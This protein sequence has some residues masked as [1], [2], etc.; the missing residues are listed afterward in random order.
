MAPLVAAV[1]ARVGLVVDGRA[2][3]VGSAPVLTHDA[4]AVVAAA[5]E[6]LCVVA[7]VAVVRVMRLFRPAAVAV[8][9]AA[10]HVQPAAHFAHVPL[11]VVRSVLVAAVA[12]CDVVHV[13]RYRCQAAVEPAVEEQLVVTRFARFAVHRVLVARLSL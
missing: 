8:A 5:A 11:A 3:L 6:H 13:V 2:A 7:P 9:R 4:S 12:P 10:L 1:V